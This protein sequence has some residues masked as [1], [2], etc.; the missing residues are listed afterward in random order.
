MSLITL[1]LRWDDVSPQ[2]YEQIRPALS[3]DGG[4]P[5]DCC[6]RTARLQGRVLLTTEVWA[7]EPA[8]NRHLAE[9]SALVGPAGLGEPVMAMFAVPDMYASAFRQ[10]AHRSRSTEPAAARSRPVPA[11]R[12]PE[13]APAGIPVR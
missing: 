6:S 8:V 9:L 11:P 7:N 4:L 10:S 5:A 12:S 13:P 2:Q 1:H 3:T